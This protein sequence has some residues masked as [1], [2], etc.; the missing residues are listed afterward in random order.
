MLDGIPRERETMLSWKSDSLTYLGGQHDLPLWD[1]PTVAISFLKREGAQATRYTR[2]RK[3]HKVV[4][5]KI[6]FSVSASLATPL[7]QQ[8]L[9]WINNPAGS[10]SGIDSYRGL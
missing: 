5:L 6:Q 1:G 10:L 9:S 3:G 7:V 4:C 2:A 8:Q